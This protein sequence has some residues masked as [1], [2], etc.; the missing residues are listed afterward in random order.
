MDFMHFE[1]VN[2]TLIASDGKQYFYDK[3]ITILLKQKGYYFNSNRKQVF[4][5]V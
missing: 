1:I 4:H 5:H 3:A 2:G